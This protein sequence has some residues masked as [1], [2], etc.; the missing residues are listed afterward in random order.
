VSVRWGFI[1]A[2]YVASRA[3]APAVHA[4]PNASLYAVASR[5]DGRSAALEPKVV[6]H[7]YIDLI[8]DPLVDAVYIS[9]TNAQHKEWV[10]AALNAGKHVLCE[11]PLAMN[12]DEVG[13]MIEAAKLNNRLLVEAVWTRWQPRMQRMAQIVKSG[14]LGEVSEISSSFTFQGDLTDNY[15]LDPALGGGALLDVGVYQ[16]H[17]WLTLLNERV[18]F[19]IDSV[20]RTMSST[21]VDLTTRAQLR[22]NNSITAH[23]L[24][25]FDLPPQQHIEVVGSTSTMRTGEGEAF[26]LWKQPSTLIIGESVEHFAPD[27]AFALMVQG[28]S[29]AIETSAMPLFPVESSLR[30]AAITDAISRYES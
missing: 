8:N 26:T 2:G 15:R 16:A 6:H 23:L 14:A 29:D 5:D 24:S 7:S 27:D 18:K 1:G 10:L 30:A 20:E 21:G 4:T 17:L 3:M 28:V 11:K 19:L 13:I 22:L 12:A 25:S 9:L